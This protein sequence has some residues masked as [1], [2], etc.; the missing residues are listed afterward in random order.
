MEKEKIFTTATFYSK[1][2]PLF[3]NVF[4]KGKLKVIYEVSRWEGYFKK[5]LR[6]NIPTSNGALR[7]ASRLGSFRSFQC[8]NLSARAVLQTS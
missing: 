1:S 3:V 2:T 4:L 5:R 7:E 8:V 6:E